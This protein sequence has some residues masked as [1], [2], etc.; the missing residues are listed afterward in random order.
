VYGPDV[1]VGVIGLGR[2]GRAVVA[3]FERT[4]TVVPWD[5]TSEEPYPEQALAECD[6]VVVSVATPSRADGSADTSQVEEALSRVPVERV[7]L[8]S[9]V[10]P[11][12][13]DR[14]ASETGKQILYWPEYVGESRYFNPFFSN[15]I[16]EVPFAILGGPAELRRYVVDRLLPILGPTKHYFQCEAKEAELIKYAENAYFATKITFVNELSRICK[17]FDVDW[18]TVREG[19][20]LDPRVEPMHTAVF[21]DAPGFSGK[22]LPKDMRAIIAAAEAQGYDATFLQAAVDANDRFQT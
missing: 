4:S 1:H 22:C 8:K 9:T 2:V 11:G 14:L 18:H 16:E 12:T 19:W 20:L 6:F 5:I 10:P 13:T 15:A 21:A 3:L 17:A 7:I